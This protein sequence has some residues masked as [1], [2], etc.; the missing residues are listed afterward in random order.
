M[1]DIKPIAGRVG[2]V[3]GIES[4]TV[5]G[6]R[7]FFGFDYSM[8][9]AVSPLIDDPARMAAF[10]SE[11][12]LQTDGPHD[13]AYWRDLVDSSVEMSDIVGE[14]EDRTFDSETLAAQR[15]TPSTQLMYLMGAATAWNDLFFEDDAVQAAFATIGVKEQ[16]REDWECLDQCIAAVGSGDAGVSM[17]AAEVMT[18]YQRFIFGNLPANWPEVFAAL[19][20][21]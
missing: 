1:V 2:H 11:H 13:A 8:D 18:A 12:M 9:T 20:P 3:G 10:A 4:M 7:W 14:D 6:R 17:A 15:L 21:R 19:A 16:D 5:D